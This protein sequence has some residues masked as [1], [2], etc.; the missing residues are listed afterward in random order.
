[1]DHLSV[2]NR[3]KCIS[4]RKLR[5]E[6]KLPAVL[7]GRGQ[8][9]KSIALSHGNFEKIWRQAGESTVITLSH[10]E[11]TLDVLIAEVQT[12]PVT[13]EFLHVDFQVLEK[14]KKVKVKVP[15][16]FVGVSPAARDL[17]ATLVK[18]LH[19]IEVEAFPNDLPHAIEVGVS[20]LDTL[21]SQILARDLRLQPG[22]TLRTNPL[23]VVA[24]VAAAR[25]E[26][27]EEPQTIDFSQIEVE[28]KGKVGE[29]QG[30]AAEAE[31]TAK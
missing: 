28:K 22:V 4:S 31:S 13:G 24:A 6:G 26:E 17:G 5:R 23:E 16:Q 20:V 2:E 1:M 9:T 14:G 27:K 15:I 3:E 29:E 12:D 30:A 19:E 7:Y 21:E 10:P 8:P 18:V 25:E 11:G